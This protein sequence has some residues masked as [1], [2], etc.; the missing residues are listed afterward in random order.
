MIQEAM[1]KH[2]DSLPFHNSRYLLAFLER[3]SAT[4]ERE[5]NLVIGNR[6][7]GNGMLYAESETAAYSGQMGR[8]RELVGRAVE[9]LQRDGNSEAAGGFTAEAAVREALVGNREQAKRQVEGAF[10]LTDNP[11]TQVTGALVLAL[12]GETEKATKIVSTLAE[13]FPANTSMQLQYLPMVRAALAMGTGNGTKA[14]EAFA[15]VGNVEQGSPQYMNYLRMYPV[16]MHGMACLS[17][18][19][20]A[21]AAIEFQKII[22]RPGL[23]LNEPVG[24]WARLGLARALAQSGETE[25][26][27]TAYQ[28]FLGIWKDADPDVPM[29]KQAKAEYAKLQ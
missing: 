3:D 9:N 28:D 13:R 6:T 17:A 7:F 29:L 4:M 14:V 12:S 16:Y 15:K 25:K 21:Q 8:A 24:A 19:Q 5:A 20:G 1:S 11:F 22:D 10:R 18:R 26:A 27:R 23:V 2:P